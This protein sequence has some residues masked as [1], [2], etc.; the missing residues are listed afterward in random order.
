MDSDRTLYLLF[1]FCFIAPISRADYSGEDYEQMKII[2]FTEE[3]ASYHGARCLDGS[4]SAYYYRQGYYEKRWVISLGG[5]VP[6]TTNQSCQTALKDDDQLSSKTMDEFQEGQYLLYPG[7]RNNFDFCVWNHVLIPSCSRDVHSGQRRSPTSWGH[8]FAGH[9][10]IQAVISDLVNKT[11]FTNASKVIISGI[12]E[13]G[14]A[15]IEHADYFTETIHWA[16]VKVVSIAG[17]YVP[18][19]LLPYPDRPSESV[20]PDFNNRPP[21]LHK[22]YHEVFQSFTHTDCTNQ[23]VEEPH[24]CGPTN[25]GFLYQYVKTPLYIAQIQYDFR[26]MFFYLNCQCSVLTNDESYQNYTSLFGRRMFL[27]MRKILHSGK[28]DGVFGPACYG[29]I[30]DLDLYESVTI[31]RASFG[32][33]LR[34]WYFNDTKSGKQ[35]IDHCGY[36]GCNPQCT[37]YHG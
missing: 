4:P 37:S 34:S 30:L 20:P 24:L 31:Y 11:D 2:K 17:Y 22:H 26:Q 15:A 13:G 5:G 23:N 1:L 12:Q 8:Y 10:T 33:S 19:G 9:L 28:G 36:H 27:E 32:D 21:L 18:E 16:N 3:Q 29:D 6:C 14:A 25:V 35:I 7:R